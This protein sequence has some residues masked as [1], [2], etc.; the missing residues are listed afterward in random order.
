MDKICKIDGFSMR[1]IINKF[2]T[3]CYYNENDEFHREDGPA[4]E[5][6]DGSKT[7]IKNGL[8]HREDGPAIECANNYKTWCKNGKL[9][10]ED[11]PAIEYVEGD[12][13]YWYNDIWYKEIKTDEEWIRFVKLIIFK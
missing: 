2:K 3:I 9:H 4:I 7:W 6:A 11:G 1:K 8:Y 13:E 12:K 10:R 5:Y